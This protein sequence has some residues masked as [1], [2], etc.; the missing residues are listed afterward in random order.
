MESTPVTQRVLDAAALIL[1]TAAIHTEQTGCHTTTAFTY[2]EDRT[3]ETY[4]LNRTELAQAARIA[5]GAAFGCGVYFLRAMTEATIRVNALKRAAASIAKDHPPKDQ[6]SCSSETFSP[7][8]SPYSPMNSSTKSGRHSTPR[9]PR[10][11]V[12]RLMAL[13]EFFPATPKPDNTNT[14][15]VP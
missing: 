1:T 3:A 5:T 10:W 11:L 7:N 12:T 2:A 13:R 9:R 15:M 14:I 8:L 6:P 4:Q